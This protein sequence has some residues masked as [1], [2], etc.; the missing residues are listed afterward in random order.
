MGKKLLLKDNHIHTLKPSYIT[1]FKKIFDGLGPGIITGAADDDPSGIAT[2]SQTG[3]AFGFQH[4]YLSIITFPLMSLIQE[5]CGRLALVTGRGLS[6]NIRLHFPRKILFISTIL[7][8]IANTFNIS[9]DISAV[10]ATIHLLFPFIHK[11]IIAVMITFG[12]TVTLIFSSYTNYAKYL[13]YLTFTLFAYI[14]TAF[15]INIDIQEL[16]QNI[17][18]PTITFSKDQFFIITAIF[19]TTISPYLF[20][21][22]TGEEVEEEIAQ[23]KT[24]LRLRDGCSSEEITTMRKDVWTGMFFSNII[25]F[26]IIVVSGATLHLNGITTI[27]SPEE[28]ALALKPL[29]GNYAF[30]LFALGIIGTGLLAIPVLITSS[31]YALGETYKWRVGLYKKFGAAKK[32]YTSIIVFMSI[33]LMC[34]TL[35][36]NPIQFLLYSAICNAIVAPIVIVLITKLTANKSIMKRFV[37]SK[38]T[39]YLGYA[40]AFLMATIA[41]ITAILSIL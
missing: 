24:N 18:F 30:L 26:F 41:I 21:W 15:M 2:Y 20:Y 1:S 29:A 28:A 37:N 16:L 31:A 19:G 8:V 3:A 22:Q 34:S 23:G 39:T 14:I 4:A 17:L 12:I 11:N 40:L 6:G 33:A 35:F 25:M 38:L 13:K 27:N 7:L 32:F 10:S 9:A 36:D 5:M